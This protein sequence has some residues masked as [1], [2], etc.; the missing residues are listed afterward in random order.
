MR[1]NY[2]SATTPIHIFWG[3]PKVSLPETMRNVVTGLGRYNPRNA[4]LGGMDCLQPRTHMVTSSNGK[5][6]RVTG[7]LWGEGQWH[8]ALMFSLICAWPN[9]WVNNRD[10]GD[11]RWYRA[12]Y[13]VTA[14]NGLH[15]RSGE[16]DLFPMLMQQTHLTNPTKH[17][18]H[19]H[20]AL[21]R[22]E[23]CTFLFWIGCIAGYEA[24]ALWDL[25]I[26]SIGYDLRSGHLSTKKG[27]P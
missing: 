25:W 15:V 19:I 23:I 24:G 12:H 5:I 11:L 17:L 2:F 8:G 18:S 1:S 6:F 3:N 14:M 21:F 22:T 4:R 27:N 13:D 9:G 7:P 16:T 10:A 20:N 26:W